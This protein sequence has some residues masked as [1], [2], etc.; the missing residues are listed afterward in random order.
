MTLH[1]STTLPLFE[2][3]VMSANVRENIPLFLS[4]DVLMSLK[5]GAVKVKSKNI[6]VKCMNV[7]AERILALV[8]EEKQISET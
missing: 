7:L 1:D 5:I 8:P 6:K 3:S 4:I 2:P